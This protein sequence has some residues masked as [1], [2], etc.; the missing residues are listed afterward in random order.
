MEYWNNVKLEKRNFLNEQGLFCHFFFN[1]F[2]VNGCEVSH[3]LLSLGSFHLLSE[4]A[5]SF[6][7][8]M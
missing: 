6:E 1:F 4:T 5:P 7:M 3:L 2:F 8:F